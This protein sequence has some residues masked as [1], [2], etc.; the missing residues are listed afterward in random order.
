MMGKLVMEQVRGEGIKGVTW[1][2][3]HPCLLPR[4]TGDGTWERAEKA[5]TRQRYT[6]W[7]FPRRAAWRETRHFIKCGRTARFCPPN[8][9]WS[10][11]SFNG[12]I[13][14]PEQPTYLD[15]GRKGQQS[16]CLDIYISV[17]SGL[18]NYHF[19]KLF[20]VNSTSLLAIFIPSSCPVHDGIWVHEQ[21]KAPST[22]REAWDSSVGFS[23]FCCPLL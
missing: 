19:R 20:S 1:K 21:K 8:L 15:W 6:W 22:E 14:F 16:D 10:S 11:F 5:G 2:C 12:S 3:R 9:K 23:G 18:R 4:P 7:M 13:L 17:S